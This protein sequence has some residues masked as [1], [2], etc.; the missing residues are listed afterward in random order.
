MP[1]N[2]LPVELLKVLGIV[3][4]GQSGC[5]CFKVVYEVGQFQIRRS[6]DEH[7]YMVGFAVEFF[8]SASP[9]IA[10]F[11]SQR[12]NELQYLRCQDTSAVLCH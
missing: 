7:M 12:F 10:D 4:S 3:L 5:N 1:E 6:I 9:G 11:G 8:K 2:R